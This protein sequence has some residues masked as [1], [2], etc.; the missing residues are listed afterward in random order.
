MNGKT[1]LIFVVIGIGVLLLASE[2]FMNGGTLKVMPKKSDYA[3]LEKNM[4]TDLLE[5]VH[6]EPFFIDLSNNQ[7]SL[8]ISK[9]PLQKVADAIAQQAR[10]S[11]IFDRDMPNP[12]IDM[13]LSNLPVQQ[14]LQQLFENYDSFF[15]YSN[16]KQ[17]IARLRTVWV[18][19]QGQGQKLAPVSSPIAAHSNEQ[20]QDT[21]DPEADKR[22]SAIAS[23]VEQQGSAASERVQNALMDPDERVRMQ[24]LHSALLAQ[25]DLPLDTL[26][27]LAQRDASAKIRSI[28]LAGL[29]NRS[30]QGA[31][32]LSDVLE[33]LSMAQKDND[34]EVSELAIQLTKSVEEASAD[35]ESQELQQQ[36]LDPQLEWRPLEAN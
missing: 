13:K 32:E 5:T 12:D 1:V 34:S 33:V 19:P 10:I 4:R 18:Y 11:I 22:A 20:I 7:L 26:K 31:F 2:G 14:G 29:V 25:I 6:S 15:F 35:P 23:L 30:E 24:A 9:Q 3:S 36:S 28:A 16:E 27:D 17:R 21:I 8:S